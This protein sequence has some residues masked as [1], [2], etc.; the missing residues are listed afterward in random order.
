[1]HRNDCYQT[2]Q[3]FEV[4]PLDQDRRGEARRAESGLGF[5]GRGSQPLPPD[6]GLWQRCKLTQ[7]DPG[8]AGRR[9]VFLYS[10]PSDCLSQHLST[11]CIQFAWISI[12]FFQRV[13]H[14]NISDINRWGVRS[15]AYPRFRRLCNGV[16][17][18]TYVSQGSAA[19]HLRGGSSFN[20]T[21]L[22][23][24]FMNLT[25]KKYENRPT[26]A[27]V[28]VK[29]KVSHFFQTRCTL[30]R[31][32]VELMQQRRTIRCTEKKTRTLLALLWPKTS[33]N[34][35]LLSL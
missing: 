31:E 27:E 26:V 32:P 35:H 1:M 14:I 10:L 13:I 20:S 8:S 11:C 3:G 4:F 33:A 19:T 23:R 30:S 22:L 9:R 2:L 16:Q 12:R 6:R 28:I 24:S 18:T 25:V 17:L 15:P 34:V 5:L 21:F 7:R 29:I